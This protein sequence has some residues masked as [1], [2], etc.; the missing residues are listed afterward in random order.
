[1]NYPLQLITKNN[2]SEERYLGMNA[3]ANYSLFVRFP[4]ILENSPKRN[5]FK[6]RPVEVK[7]ISEYQNN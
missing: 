6:Q 5:Y 2:F 4:H 7:T 1:M 3:C